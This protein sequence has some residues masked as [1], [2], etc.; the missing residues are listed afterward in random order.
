MPLKGYHTVL[1]T[2]L[3]TLAA[4]IPTALVAIA[5]YLALFTTASLAEESRALT[6]VLL[7]ASVCG[8]VGA[9]VTSYAYL[10][11]AG[12]WILDCIAQNSVSNLNHTDS[13]S[14]KRIMKQYGFGHL[15]LAGML[16]CFVTYALALAS[17]AILLAHHDLGAWGIAVCSVGGVFVL[18]CFGHWLMLRY[19][20]RDMD[21]E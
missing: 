19:N 9:G 1:I 20:D 21:A 17:I 4:V 7:W 11:F 10:E 5:S 16:L 12:T 6:I 13:R 8:L 3:Q 14:A 15:Y 18:G 2:G